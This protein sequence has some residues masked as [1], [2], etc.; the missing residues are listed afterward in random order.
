M[1]ELVA[2]RV[3]T[4]RQFV[5]AWDRIE[6]E[7]H[8]LLPLDFGAPDDH[9]ADLLRRLRPAALVT[10][11]PGAP[12]T[13]RTIRLEDPAT[14][15]DGTAAVVATSGTTGQ[16][17]G[18][19]LSA[20]ALEASTR[21]SVERL[22]CVDGEPWLLCLPWHHVAGMAVIRRSRHLGADPVLHDRFDLDEVAMAIGDGT[23]RWVS[24]VPTQLSR[25]LDAG[26]P[27]SRL[28]GVLLGGAAASADLLDRA[29]E[30]DVRITTSYGM[31]ETCGGCVYDG[32]PLTDTAVALDPDGT[33]RLSGATI[34]DGYHLDELATARAFD[35][36]AYLTNDLGAFDEHGKLVVLGRRDEVVISGGEN[37]PT[38]RVAEVLE[39]QA[40]IAEA[41]VVG[42]D[43]AEW[44][45][46]VVAVVVS[47]DGTLPNLTA[48]RTAVGKVLPAAWAPKD[49]VLTD[50]LPR[51]SLGKVD[52]DAARRLARTALPPA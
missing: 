20:A 34:A 35:R 40:G 12:S 32:E 44:G 8:A 52:L 4:A 11:H 25:L 46:R 45:Q 26:A 47:A 2:V 3:P 14:V 30:A 24:L 23:A 37:V 1:A 9:N 33:I 42:I 41:A 49:V 36:D 39:S 21:A 50:R 31:T 22:A 5:E 13:T 28:R 19:V 15:P 27:L 43:D 10:T 29:R 38:G 7:G 18:V 51:T 48:L 17:K 16:P 6:A